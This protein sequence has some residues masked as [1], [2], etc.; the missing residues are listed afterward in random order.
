MPPWSEGRADLL[1]TKGNQNMQ[2][3]VLDMTA[4]D[5]SIWRVCRGWAKSLLPPMP[6]EE[7]DYTADEVLSFA[8][9]HSRLPTTMTEL[10]AWLA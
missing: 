10:E 7:L 4:P 3:L 8:K 2:G 1:K 5:D 9:E 6:T